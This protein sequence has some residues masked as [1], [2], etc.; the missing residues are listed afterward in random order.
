MGIGSTY[1]FVVY[2]VLC[3]LKKYSF[4]E[5]FFEKFFSLFHTA[6]QNIWEIVAFFLRNPVI[7]S[8]YFPR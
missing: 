6:R 5:L 1:L 4:G 7:V 8:L 3:S 2:Q